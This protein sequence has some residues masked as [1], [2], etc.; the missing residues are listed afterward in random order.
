[1][2]IYLDCCDFLMV[3]ILLMYRIYGVSFLVWVNKLWILVE[4]MLE[5]IF[6]KFD[7]VIVRKGILVFVVIV[8]VRRVLFVFGG[9][10][11]RVF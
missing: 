7:L 11:R 3:F 8:F 10:M 5:N 9:L 4:L 1:M 6:I 2:E